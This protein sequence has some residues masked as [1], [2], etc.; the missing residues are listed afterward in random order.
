M[1]PLPSSYV[2]PFIGKQ[3]ARHGLAWGGVDRP[4]PFAF[5]VLAVSGAGKGEANGI[6]FRAPRSKEG[7]LLLVALRLRIPSV[8]VIENVGRER[9]GGGGKGHT[10]FTP[11]GAFGS[12]YLVCVFL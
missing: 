1:W 10:V 6:P 2:P 4:V 12:S 11:R 7:G 8:L 3:G 9:E 5:P